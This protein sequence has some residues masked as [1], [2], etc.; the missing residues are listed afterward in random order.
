VF[1]ASDGHLYVVKSRTHLSPRYQVN[2]GVASSLGSLIDAPTPKPT[3]LRVEAGHLMGVPELADFR[4]G[5][6]YATLQ[7][8]DLS[9]RLTFQQA[10]QAYNRSRLARLAILYAWIG[11]MSDQQLMYRTTGDLLVFSLDH[12]Q[13]IVNSGIWQLADLTVPVSLSPDAWIVSG[14]NISIDELRNE[15]HLLADVKPEGVA[16]AV[17]FPPEAW[18]ITSS[19]RQGLANYLWQR[20]SL[21]LESI[22]APTP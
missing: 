22:Q 20:R 7:D 21:L 18:G 6:C 12:E 16:S 2:D 17:S 14:A 15:L 11:V 8:N 19:E 10:H 3:I 5:D 13:S 1:K 4:P 9:N